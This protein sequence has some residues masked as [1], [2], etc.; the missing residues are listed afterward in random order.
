MNLSDFEVI[1]PNQI[2]KELSD[3]L[4]KEF[5]KYFYQLAM[6]PNIHLNY[7]VV[8]DVYI[9]MFE[10]KGLKKGDAVIGGFAEWKKIDQIVS[11]NRDFLRGLAKEHYFEVLSPEEFCEKFFL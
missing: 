11:N 2:R 10:H 4:S 6:Q 8:P 7:E 5:L 9:A 3:N 1:V